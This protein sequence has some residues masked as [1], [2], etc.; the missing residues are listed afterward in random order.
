MGNSREPRTFRKSWGLLAFGISVVAAA[1]LYA[2]WLC[3]SGRGG[4]DRS[5]PALMVVVVMVAG[6]GAMFAMLSNFSIAVNAAGVSKRGL[7]SRKFIGWQEIE[8]LERDSGISIVAKSGRTIRFSPYVFR[9]TQALYEYI[10]K[11]I[12][13]AQTQ[14]SG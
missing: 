14:R 13:S 2:L 4:P 11:R 12:A 5:G 6:A 10:E 7:L 9:D 3:I 1:L 8:R